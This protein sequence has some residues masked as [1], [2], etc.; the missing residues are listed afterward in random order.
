MTARPKEQSVL[1]GQHHSRRRQGSRGTVDRICLRAGQVPVQAL[2]EGQGG[3]Q[4]QGQ[5]VAILRRM[6]CR[7]GYPL[8]DCPLHPPH[9][10]LLGSLSQKPAWERGLAA[11]TSKG[12]LC[13]VHAPCPGSRVRV[14]LT[15]VPVA[16]H[17]TKWPFTYCSTASR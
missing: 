4:L 16:E 3:P 1:H 10:V 14:A 17:L 2:E 12:G 13:A 11:R 6:A 15:Q 5:H 7:L 8:G 9:N